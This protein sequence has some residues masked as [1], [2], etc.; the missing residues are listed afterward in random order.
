LF[1]VC[2]ALYNWRAADSV[3]W[4]CGFWYKAVIRNCYSDGAATASERHR[5]VRRNPSDDASGTAA[6][7]GAV[8]T[9]RRFRYE[10]AGSATRQATGAW[11]ARSMALPLSPGQLCHWRAASLAGTWRQQTPAAL[12]ARRGARQLR[13]CGAAQARQRVPRCRAQ[14]GYAAAGRRAAP[15]R[16]VQ[17]EVAEACAQRRGAQEGFSRGPGPSRTGRRAFLEESQTKPLP[18]RIPFSA[19]SDGGVGC[20]RTPLSDAFPEPFGQ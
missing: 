10:A 18:P 15:Q 7:S 16:A 13:G 11:P 19:L 12:R 4:A 3:L 8:S 17:A 14:P 9:P 5:G 20:R 2:G 1:A 6:S